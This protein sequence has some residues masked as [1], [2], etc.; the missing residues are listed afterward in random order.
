MTP[1]NFFPRKGSSVAA[2]LM[3]PSGELRARTPRW[4]ALRRATSA[5][6]MKPVAPVTRTASVTEQTRTQALE[7]LDRLRVVVRAADVEPVPG[8][9]QQARRPARP[10]E[11]QHELVEA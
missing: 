9:A 7:V 2:A 3:S 10:D 8:V 6:P 4:S 5:R 1:L 11:V